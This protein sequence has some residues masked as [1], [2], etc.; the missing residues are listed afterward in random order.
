[1]L[2]FSD[3]CR[4]WFSKLTYSRLLA[5]TIYDFFFVDT[6]PSREWV[7]ALFLDVYLPLLCMIFSLL[8]LFLLGS[9]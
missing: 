9:G 5:S 8:T 2:I 7:N 3:L 4:R 1:M 6:F